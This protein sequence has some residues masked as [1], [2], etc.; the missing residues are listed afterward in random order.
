MDEILVKT[1]GS[2]SQELVQVEEERR[3]DF[4]MAFI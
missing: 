4:Y 1:K 3:V 2:L